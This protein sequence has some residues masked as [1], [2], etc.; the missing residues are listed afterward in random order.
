MLE[1]K[2]R[3]FSHPRRRGGGVVVQVQL[4]SIGWETTSTRR[5]FLQLSAT[6]RQSVRDTTVVEVS[7]LN[8]IHVV[9]LKS[10]SQ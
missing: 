3:A 5:S 8:L 10:K 2:Y 7:K 4:N 1:Y 6:R 9:E